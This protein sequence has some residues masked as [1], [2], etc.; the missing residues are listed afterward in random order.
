VAEYEVDADDG[1]DFDGFAIDH[2]RTVAPGSCRVF[3][4]AP[5]QS[6]TLNDLQ[7]L[8]GAVFGD[9]GLHDDLSLHVGQTG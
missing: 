8:D 1:G 6:M 4:G 5:Q 9:D 3:C 7:V 2:V